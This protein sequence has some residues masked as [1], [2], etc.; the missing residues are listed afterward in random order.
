MTSFVDLDIENYK[1]NDILNLFK[2]PM[3]FNEN[4]LKSA[5]KKT[6]MMHPDKSKL[7]KEYFLFYSNAYKK[8]FNIYKRTKIIK[9]SNKTH[10]FI[11]STFSGRYIVFTIPLMTTTSI[12]PQIWCVIFS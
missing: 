8:L 5:K 11:K 3:D 9:F 4:D 12:R 10:F 6:L 7:P 2:V 1:L